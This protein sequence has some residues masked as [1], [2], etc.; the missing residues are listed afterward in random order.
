VPSPTEDRDIKMIEG[1][2]CLEENQGR[3]WT[4]DAL[5]SSQAK[6]GVNQQKP[7]SVFCNY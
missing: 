3:F 2:A 1:E 7:S 5:W 6:G 4:L